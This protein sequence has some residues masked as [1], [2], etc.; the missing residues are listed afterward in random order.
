MHGTHLKDF[1]LEQHECDTTNT[2]VAIEILMK[3]W[4]TCRMWICWKMSGFRLYLG[5]WRKM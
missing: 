2:W 5:K 4:F 3:A 1:T